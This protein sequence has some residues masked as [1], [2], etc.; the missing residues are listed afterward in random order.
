MS[1]K[2]KEPTLSEMFSEIK[3]GNKK[4]EQSLDCME[5]KLD[6]YQKELKDYIE[7]N[8]AAVKGLRSE[9]SNLTARLTTTEAT[10]NDMEKRLTTLSDEL[11]ET[12]KKCHDNET[13]IDRLTTSDRERMEEKKRSN[14]VIDG[15]PEDRDEPV[16]A[17]VTR[18]LVDIGVNIQSIQIVTAFRVGTISKVNKARP[19]SIILKLSSPSRKFEV[20]KSVKNL[21]GGDTWKRVFISDDLPREIADQRKELRCLAATARDR[22]HRATVRGAALVINDI[23]CTYQDLDDLPEGITMENAKMSK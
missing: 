20:Y 1:D 2:K 8:D 4:T 13:T 18:M 12:R 9:V 7:S 6:R 19:R 5:K 17:T 15:I 21:K 14:L 10:V 11:E 23:R 16:I 3:K 22:G